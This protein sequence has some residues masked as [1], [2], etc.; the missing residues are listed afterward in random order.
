[1]DRPPARRSPHP[2]RGALRTPRRDPSRGQ[3]RPLLP[4]RGPLDRGH[5]PAARPWV[6]ERPSASRRDQCLGGAR[7]PL[8]AAVLTAATRAVGS[9]PRFWGGP[10][11]VPDVHREPP[12]VGTD[13]ARKLPRELRH[14]GRAD[15]ERHAFGGHEDPG[16]RVGVDCVKMADDGTPHPTSVTPRT[17]EPG[18]AEVANARVLDL[19]DLV[20]MDP[21]ASQDAPR[22]QMGVTDRVRG[23]QVPD[24]EEDEEQEDDLE[25]PP[26]AKSG[27][28]QDDE[29]EED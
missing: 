13:P 4:D 3:A 26:L 6:R 2:E 18:G 12:G 11:R 19:A 15:V 20:E 16:G 22:P 17:D 7:R 29:E 27:V 5:T 9:L 21:S 25:G 28:R 23:R 8:T 24:E 14:V 1:G 10:L